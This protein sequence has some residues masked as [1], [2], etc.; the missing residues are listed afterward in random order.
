MFD[1]GIAT[2]A[3]IE[4]LI[5][6]VDPL[7]SGGTDESSNGNGSLMRILPLMFY[8]KDMPVA[9]RYRH[10]SESSSITHAHTR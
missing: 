2:G 6:G 7:N 5:A 10:V 4:R 8:I 9:E 3:A 1:K